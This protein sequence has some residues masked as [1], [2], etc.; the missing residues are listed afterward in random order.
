MKKRLLA[1]VLT[2]V[3]LLA[4]LPTAALAAGG[5]T[6]ISEI[7]HIDRGY[8]HIERDLAALGADIR[9]TEPAAA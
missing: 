4:L 9:R 5:E 6:V 7:T 2:L 1:C 3:M 8:E